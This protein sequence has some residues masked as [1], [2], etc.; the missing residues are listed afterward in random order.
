M[1]E[2]IRSHIGLLTE[3]EEAQQEAF[4]QL[5]KAG[6][7]ETLKDM[8]LQIRQ[9]GDPTAMVFDWRSHFSPDAWVT[10]RYD[11]QDRRDR[12]IYNR[13]GIRSR[14][15]AVWWMSKG[16]AIW[17][18]RDK[19][20]GVRY[21]DQVSPWNSLAKSGKPP[22]QEQLA[23]AK[24]HAEYHKDLRFGTGHSSWCAYPKSNYFHRDLF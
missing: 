19:I 11:L 12:E 10:L 6:A 23:F 3:R 20:M 18:Y 16:I 8:A 14:K 22:L 15:E 24:D 5:E 13:L 2:G 9:D 4:R 21:T 17:A 1:F 7:V